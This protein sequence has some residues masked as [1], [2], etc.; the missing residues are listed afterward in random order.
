MRARDKVSASLIVVGVAVLAIP[1]PGATIAF[2][3]ITSSSGTGGPSWFGGHGVE[4][5]DVT[6]DDRPDFYVTMN[7]DTN[8]GELFYRNING[9]TFAEEADARG[10]YNYDSGS[11]GGVW[12]DLDNDGDYDLVNGSYERNRAYENNGSGYFTDRTTTC[13]FLNV[14]LGTRGTLAFDYDKDGDLDVFCNNWEPN[15][16][17]NE[18]YRNDGNWQFTSITNNGLG[19]STLGAQGATEGDFDN[20]GDLDILLCRYGNGPL[21][22]MRNDNG[23]FTQLSPFAST[24][25][26]QD[27]ATF[28]DVNND[29]WLDV[30]SMN[31]T[32]LGIGTAKLFINNKN[33]TFTEVS[34][35]TGPGFM[36]GFEDLDNDGD[37]DMVYPGDNKVYLN[38]GSGTFTASA[39]FNP[40]T[41]MTKDPRCVAFADIDNDGDMDFFYA[42]KRYYNRMIRNDLSDGGNW[43]KVRLISP[44]N[45]AGAFG[46]KVR[47]YTAGQAGNPS[48]MISFRE[49]RSNEGY[50][51]QNDPVLH[52]GVGSRTTVDVQVT[53][54]NGLT[55]TQ[56]NVS[57]NQT[58]T[59]NAG[60]A[61]PEKASNPNPANG[62]TKVRT[63]SSLSWTAGGGAITHKVYFGTSNPPAY[64]GEQAGTSYNPGPM[65]RMTLHYWR[66]DEVNANGTT[67]GDPWTF[68]TG[69]AFGDFDEDG[70]V[71]LI[72]FGYL[73]RCYS[74]SGVA[75]ASGCGNADLDGDND[76]DQADF[77]AFKNCF[78]GADRPPGC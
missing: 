39:S 37:W 4:W 2:T 3:D 26:R 54:L 60:T 15:G 43:F 40:G 62:A 61:P 68:T 19:G 18:L 32:Y 46:A 44:N 73:Q 34:V 38:D 59:F 51:G 10:I 25:P 42:Q 11:H 53:F 7:F 27:G 30:H 78:G 17:A 23:T 65:N 52:F 49:A 72:D 35:P 71:D 20:D 12:A 76:V 1:L 41:D 63:S 48:A 70:D 22:L 14:N 75:P 55:L 67:T 8:M 56:S 6:G 13:G 64:Q 28:C 69:S 16:E 36:A 66:I 9:G 74:G 29:G 47:T 50:L 77:N 5:A 58:V 31:S 45:Q 33:G 21:L 57:A 24:S